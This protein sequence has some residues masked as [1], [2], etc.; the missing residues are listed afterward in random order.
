MPMQKQLYSFLLLVL[1]LSCKK[2][3][4]SSNPDNSTVPGSFSLLQFKVDDRN[5]APYQNIS[6]SPTLSILFDGQLDS[7]T[8]ETAIQF[9]D[10]QSRPI[11]WTWKLSRSD[12]SIEIK[13]TRALNPFSRYTLCINYR[14][15]NQKGIAL[16]TNYCYALITQLDT[17]DKFERISE[18]ALLDK[19]QA[20]TFKY[21]WDFAHPV[22]GLSRERNSSGDLVTIGGSGFGI[23][24]IP[25]AIN[26]AFITRAEGV[27]RL[28][29]IVGFLDTKVVK[30]HG[31][32]PH[33][34]S[35]TT[36][37]T[38][39][40]GTKDN[41]ADLVETSFLMQGLLTARQYFDRNT[42]DENYIRE[43]IT[44]LYQNVEWNWFRQNGKNTLYWH[45]SPDQ[46]WAMNMTVS[47]WNEGLI[48]YIMAL[49]DETD[50]IPAI[51][52]QNGF[53]RN[54]AMKNGNSYY[55]YK[56][57][58]GESLGG[59]L[60]FTHYSFLGVNPNG[61][62]DQYA[63]YWEQNSN[64]SLIN[65]SYCV[66]NPKKYN[67]YGA[68]CWGLTASDN[69]H[70][71]Y[72]AHSPTNDQGIISP[73]AALSS[74]PYTPQESMKAL[75]FF[76]YKLGDKLFKEYGFVDAFNPNS[77]WFANSF[78]AIDQGPIVIMIENYRSGLCW[79]L[80]MSCPEIKKGMKKMGFSS[81][82]L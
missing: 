19:V 25:V 23:M 22:S 10:E 76:Y 35:G 1:L 4:D 9:T 71:G 44:K 14:L 77:P 47:G 72:S 78:L 41:G 24:T 81:P 57:P 29:K 5:E 32:F 33:W 20:Q 27:E 62:S 46:G 69:N 28:K 79:N 54:G 49:S 65:Y 58:L 55:G 82:Y 74:M 64:H 40:F 18:D 11:F 17:S 38:I 31:A 67:L 39:P 21:F 63:D 51:V 60:F 70:Q 42:E 3:E 26:R 34:L 2:N 45:W 53:A 56:L 50:S 36:G 52:Y 59:P 12:S 8:I 61:L 43:T 7:Q 73:T 30:Y 80:F 13:P 6:I 68:N 37:N 48:T 16:T 75:N 15:K 66:A